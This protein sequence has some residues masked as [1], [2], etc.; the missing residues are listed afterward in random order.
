MVPPPDSPETST[1][2]SST[3]VRVDIPDLPGAI[4]SSA[5]G[6]VFLGPPAVPGWVW[7]PEAIPEVDQADAEEA[8]A[9]LRAAPWHAA[10][11]GGAGVRVAV[12]DSQFADWE[13][14]TPELGDVTTH[15]CFAHRSCDLPIDSYNR[16]PSTGR[17]GIACAEVIHDIA[18]DAELH[19]VSV[20]SLTA[21]E[22]AV[23]WAIREEVDLISMS[24]SF[25][26]ESAYDGTGPVNAAVDRLAAHNI[27]LVTSAGNYAEEHWGGPFAD[28]D[29]DGRHD[30]QPGDNGLWVYWNPGVRRI[31]LVWD[32]WQS[33]GSTDLDV[34]VYG[35]DG[36]LAGRS[37]E[38][39]LP[40]ALRDDDRACQPVERVSVNATEEGWYWVVLHHVAGD[41][42]VQIDLFARSGEVWEGVPGGSIVDPGTHPAVFT[43]GAVRASDYLHLG[44]ESFSSQ[45]PTNNGLPKPDIAGPNGL[46]TTA[47]GPIGFYGT[48][49]AT[50]AVTG[51]LAVLM[52]EDPDLD[53]AAAAKKLKATALGEHATWEVDDGLGAGRARLPSLESGDGGC[54]FGPVLPMIVVF[55]LFR[56]RRRSPRPPLT[57]Y[58][59][60]T[61]A[62]QC[63]SEN[64]CA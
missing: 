43:V 60:S 35:P 31:E 15:D 1:I 2:S 41:T 10:G 28:L 34:Y 29:H 62:P 37:M 32:D 52:G 49:A 47:Y 3:L 6:S 36:N 64:P 48:S 20:T 12:F 53:G 44:P 33:C 45:G 56:L 7:R 14:Y 16:L 13:A 46:T 58:T 24:L 63:P 19:L 30:F 18:P 42:D 59:T 55:P 4:A 50:P 38:R 11:E 57:G 17:H 39:Q 54:G 51:A 5:Q 40:Q 23:D 22:N 26:N 8:I 9:A 27:L 61:R 25:F 21:F